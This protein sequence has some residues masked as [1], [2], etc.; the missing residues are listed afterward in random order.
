MRT[1]VLALALLTL[2]VVPP[3]GSA[4]KTPPDF[5]VTDIRIS[6]EP[7]SDDPALDGIVLVIEVDVANIGRTAGTGFVTVWADA[8][9]QGVDTRST[10]GR[11]LLDLPERGGTTVVLRWTPIAAG[12]LTI[13][14]QAWCEQDS[15]HTN[16]E[17]SESAQAYVDGDGSGITVR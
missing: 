13:V 2:S 15:D 6:A 10:I 3:V 8:T 5:T 14:A 17:A 11:P 12:D 9:I 16:D 1:I 7:L 4:L